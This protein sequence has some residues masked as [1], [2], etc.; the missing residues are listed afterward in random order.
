MGDWTA[1]VLAGRRPGENDF[2]A[3]HGVAAKALIRAGGEPMLGRVA[4]VLLDSPSIGR[5]VILAQ[6]AEALLAGE[7]EWMA[8]E[9][10]IATAQSGDG[11][12]AS[13]G[14]LAGTSAAPYPVLVTTADHALLQP[15]MVEYFIAGASGVDVAFAMV[16]RKTVEKAHP[17]T[18]RTWLKTANGHFSGA[19][20]F[21]LLTPESA[22]GTS[23]WARAEKDRKRTLKLLTFL[24]LG[25]FL[26]AVT[27]TI[28]LEA[29][30]ERAGRKAGFRLRAVPLPFAEAAIDVDKPSDL[31]LAERILAARA[32]LPAAA[33][34]AAATAAGRSSAP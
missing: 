21:A 7:L 5:I 19:N 16:E 24:G 2:A 32:A 29:A 27:R 6:E 13:V 9:P 22:L 23:F 20:L 31:D 10:R 14:R 28:S 18:K 11:I 26:R 3:A 33:A 8:S 25:T 30:A 17:D 15:E 1:I 12:S 34:A 4:R